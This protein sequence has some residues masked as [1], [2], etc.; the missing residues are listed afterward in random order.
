MREWAAMS[1]AIRWQSMPR[2]T[3]DCCTRSSASV[4]PDSTL[5]EGPLIAARSSAPSA[6][7]SAS[8]AGSETLSI[9]PEGTRSNSCPRSSTRRTA[10]RNSNTPARQAAVFSP[11]LWPPT[12]SGC[13]P[14]EMNSFASA[15]STIISSGNCTEGWVSAASAAASSP[16]AGS[17]TPR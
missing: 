15:Y 13:T 6:S 8:C 3:S 9:P 12:A 17:Q 11:M 4:G 5:S 14:Q 7:A 2:A 16:G 10:S 1:M